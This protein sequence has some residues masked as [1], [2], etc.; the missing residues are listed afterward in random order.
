[1]TNV[2]LTI[3]YAIIGLVC[4]SLS[5]F[6]LRSNEQ[7]AK[8]GTALFWSILGIIFIFG[9]WIPANRWGINY[10]DGCFISNETS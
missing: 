8:V 6:A 10:C 3:I 1:M 5:V 9:D 4:I 2:L 7:Q